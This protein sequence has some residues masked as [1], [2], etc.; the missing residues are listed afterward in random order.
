MSGNLHKFTSETAEHGSPPDVIESSRAAL[1][2]CIDLDPASNATFNKVVQANK[3]YT[4][5]S[6][7]FTKAWCGTVFLNPPGGLCDS[8]GKRVIMVKDVSFVYAN[9]KPASEHYSAICLWW[10]N[11]VDQWM[12]GGVS[13]AVF[14]G[15]SLEILQRAQAY[16]AERWPHL[17]IPTDYPFCIPDKRLMFSK[18]VGKLLAKGSSPTHA[19]VITYLPHKTDYAAGARE[20]KNQFA[21]YGAVIIPGC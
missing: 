20:F 4:E 17:G 6:N 8:K 2:G 1:G 21:K 19:N 12:N 15:F 9:G 16:R 5:R 18:Q 3:I 7:G 11:L 10:F 13:S 14:I